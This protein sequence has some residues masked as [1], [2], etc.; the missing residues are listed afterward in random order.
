[1]RFINLLINNY[2]SLIWIF[3]IFICIDFL[4]FSGKFEFRDYSFEAIF[5]S[6]TLVCILPS[7]HSSYCKSETFQTQC[8]D[9]IYGRKMNLI[10]R[11]CLLQLRN[12]EEAKRIYLNIKKSLICNNLFIFRSMQSRLNINYLIF[13]CLQHQ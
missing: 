13:P 2:E 3:C 5:A 9:F 1:M 6:T 8:W 7:F 11:I 4:I 12:K 10:Q